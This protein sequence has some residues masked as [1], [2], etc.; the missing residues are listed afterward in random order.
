VD[1][2]R[3]RSRDRDSM[4]DRQGHWL[5]DQILDAFAPLGHDLALRL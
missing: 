1:E 4:N 3:L 5:D 2:V